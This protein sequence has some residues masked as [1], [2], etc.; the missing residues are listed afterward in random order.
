VF[1]ELIYDIVIFNKGDNSHGSP[2]FGTDEGIDLIDLKYE[3]LTKQGIIKMGDLVE[4]SF[5]DELRMTCIL[6]C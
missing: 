5:F 1:D 4:L 2:A 3:K 6:S